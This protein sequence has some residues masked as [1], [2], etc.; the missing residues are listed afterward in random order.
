MIYRGTNCSLSLQITV[1]PQGAV[2]E[3]T[4]HRPR[5]S[6]ERLRVWQKRPGLLVDE[7]QKDAGAASQRKSMVGLSGRIWIYS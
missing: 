7:R 2:P 3:G 5:E 1:N 4:A 6:V